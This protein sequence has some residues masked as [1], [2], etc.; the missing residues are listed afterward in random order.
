[1]GAYL[2][3]FVARDDACPPGIADMDGPS[4]QRAIADLASGW[5]LILR[6]LMPCVILR[7][8]MF[9]FASL[10]PPGLGHRAGPLLGDAIHLMPPTG[11]S[12]TP[13]C[14]GAC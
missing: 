7:A 8:A 3:P 5:N 13:P 6:Q 4:M 1:M 9:P 10:M 14:G 11:V 2:W 12:R